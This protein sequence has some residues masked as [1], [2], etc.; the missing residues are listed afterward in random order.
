VSGADLIVEAVFEEMSVKEAVF[1]SLDELAKPGAILA[2][3]T[4]TLDVD[5]V[6]GFT[7]RPSDV[8]GLHFFS[9]AHVMKLVEVIR[10]KE[11]ADD[12]LATGMKLARSIGKIAV[13]AGVCDGFIGNRMLEHYVRMAHL[14]V[15]EGALPW[16]IDSALESWGMAMGPFR[17]GDLAGNDIG[18]AVRKRRYRE[19][20]YVR[21]ARIGDAL[22]EA[23]RF[24]QK[25]GAGWYLYRAGTR[26]PE[27]DPETVRIIE[28]YRAAESIEP[29]AIGNDEIVARC[30]LALVN[31][32]ARIIDEGVALRAPDIDVV[33]LNGYGFPRFRGGPMKYAEETGLPTVI[34]AMERFHAV[35]G[36]PFWEPAPLLRRAVAKGKTLTGEL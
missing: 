27:P 6:A 25:T 30:I 5:A 24:G 7:R 32:G 8:V 21:Y 29:R 23:G 31:E 22:C 19:R 13:V 34:A 17:M 3:N 12:V 4:S 2:T 16:K 14:M 15:E 11:T 35:S 18:W 10:G 9:P 28:T 26:K 1:R 20:P 33:Y 36:D